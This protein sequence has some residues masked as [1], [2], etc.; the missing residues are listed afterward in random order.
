[1]EAHIS[2]TMTKKDLRYFV[3]RHAYT[4]MSGIM[5][6]VISLISLIYLILGGGDTPMGKLLLLFMALLF[7]VIQPVML[8]QRVD[9]QFKT[10]Q[11]FQNTLEYTLS[12]EGIGVLQ[13]EQKGMIPW[14]NLRKL[15]E[16]KDYILI[17]VTAR[18]A[19]VFPKNQLEGKA[20][21]VKDVIRTFMK[22]SKCHWK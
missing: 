19:F 17:Y 13:G 3:L 12:E 22:P 18:R 11:A 14:E 4:G 16:T 5:G 6:I 7:T 1:M 9:R 8:I 21:S 10:S 2:I 20:E 15:I